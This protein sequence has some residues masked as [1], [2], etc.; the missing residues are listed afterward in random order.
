MQRAAAGMARGWSKAQAGWQRCGGC[1]RLANRCAHP[2]ILTLIPS[3]VA[4]LPAAPA[5]DACSELSSIFTFCLQPGYYGERQAGD[6]AYNAP[7]VC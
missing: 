3:C 4:C 7:Q 2:L 5:P 6:E 1:A